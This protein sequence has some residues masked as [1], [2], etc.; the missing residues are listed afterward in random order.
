MI[1]N[2]KNLNHLQDEGNQ[3]GSID[4]NTTQQLNNINSPE[5]NPNYLFFLGGFVEGEATVRGSTAHARRTPPRR[6]PGGT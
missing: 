6:S 5:F 1:K 3:Q 2:E 4:F